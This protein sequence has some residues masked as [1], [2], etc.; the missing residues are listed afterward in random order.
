MGKF[1]CWLF[2]H[3]IIHSTV[4]GTSNSSGW[5]FVCGR[6]GQIF[7]ELRKKDKIA[8]SREQP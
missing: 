2:G 6:C 7:T 1:I 8:I 4:W 5:T 3:K